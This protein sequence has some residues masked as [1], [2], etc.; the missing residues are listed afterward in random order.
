LKKIISLA[1]V[2]CLLSSMLLLVPILTVRATLVGDVNGDGHVNILDA[3]LVAN[4]FLSTPSSPNWNP[5]ADINGDGVVN[6]LDAILV[7][8][9]FGS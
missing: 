8:D 7:A 6:I 2:L 3:I 4:A 9:H 1:I 5:K